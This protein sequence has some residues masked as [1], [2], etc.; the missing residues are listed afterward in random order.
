MSAINDASIGFDRPLN[1]IISRRQAGVS[2]MKLDPLLPV[3]ISY[4]LMS[5]PHQGIAKPIYQGL[6]L[7]MSLIVNSNQLI[8]A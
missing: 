4:L 5:W 2:G 1:S 7:P 3:K 8:A 6:G